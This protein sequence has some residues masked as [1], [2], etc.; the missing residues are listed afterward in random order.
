MVIGVDGAE[1]LRGEGHGLLR[2]G[3]R[4]REFQGFYV[5][6]ETLVARCAAIGT[7]PQAGPVLSTLEVKLIAY[8][9]AHQGGAF[10]QGALFAAFRED[11]VTRQA[12]TNVSDRLLKL[13]LLVEEQR[14][15]DRVAKRWVTPELEALVR[16]Q[17]A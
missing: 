11:Q 8:A 5:E 7:P 6:K 1:R 3:A 14:G 10:S 13:G 2:Q 4:V 15:G 12:I 9:L 16:A 17:G